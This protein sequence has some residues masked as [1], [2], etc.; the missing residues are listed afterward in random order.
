M[1]KS[2]SISKTEN[3]KSMLSCCSLSWTSSWSI[4]ASSK[5]ASDKSGSGSL[6]IDSKKTFAIKHWMEKCSKEAKAVV[7]EALQ[8]APYQFGPFGEQFAQMGQV[9]LNS[10]ADGFSSACSALS[11]LA[12]EES[13]QID[14]DLPLD[15]Y[16]QAML[17]K[18]VKVA[19]DRN[20]CIVTEVRDKKRYRMANEE[21]LTLRN[22]CALWQQLRPFCMSRMAG[23]FDEFENKLLSSSAM[24]DQLLHLLQDTP[25]SF[26]LSMLPMTQQAAASELKEKEETMTIEFEAQRLELRAAKWKWFQSALA[27]DQSQMALVQS[28]PEKLQALRHRKEMSWR[29]EQAKIGERIVLA[30]CDKFLRCRPVDKFQHLHEVLH[31]YRVFVAPGMHCV[32][33]FGGRCAF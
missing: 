26:A 15:A 22:M 12:N 7:S 9:F 27:R 5:E 11:P 25:R 29:L 14:W 1:L 17:F 13:L 21:L 28:A 31:E 20:T 23:K 6:M 3:P 4:G 30:Y 32:Y 2:K 10:T 19:F 33:L 16:G 24:D 18:R 8:D